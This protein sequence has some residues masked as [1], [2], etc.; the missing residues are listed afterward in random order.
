[1]STEQAQKPEPSVESLRVLR[2][3]LVRFQLN[4]MRDYLWP[5][6]GGYPAWYIDRQKGGV[7]M[8]WGEPGKD[9][10][11]LMSP[12]QDLLDVAWALDTMRR[13]KPAHNHAIVEPRGWPLFWENEI[14]HA[15]AGLFSVISK[16]ARVWGL[17]DVRLGWSDDFGEVI[18]QGKKD[19][20]EWFENTLNEW[21][22][23]DPVAT[24]I[25]DDVAQTI[26][27]T[28]RRLEEI[29]ANWSTPVPSLYAQHPGERWVLDQFRPIARPNLSSG[30]TVGRPADPQRPVIMIRVHQ[31]RV[32]RKTWK[33]ITS[34]INDEFG[35][36]F[37]PE[38]LRRYYSDSKTDLDS[39]CKNAPA[40]G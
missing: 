37:E 10:L 19:K 24:Q 25:R 13:S 3:L 2:I 26:E 11:T 20:G 9:S 21:V 35:R 40:A 15:T 4:A 14:I 23:I 17:D 32:A 18:E 1:M 36:E 39:T 16:Q 28:I 6:S 7:M 30:K 5:G 34:A 22:N 33:Q 8:E 27:I 12:L 38:T 31:Y 29:L